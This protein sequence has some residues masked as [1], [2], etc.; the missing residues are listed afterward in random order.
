VCDRELHEGVSNKNEDEHTPA[1]PVARTMTC[2]G[3][4]TMPPLVRQP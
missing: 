3:G 2:A 1:G 4:A